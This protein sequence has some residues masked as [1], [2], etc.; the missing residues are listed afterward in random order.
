MRGLVSIPGWSTIM[1]CLLW[2]RHDN[3]TVFLHFIIQNL[4]VYR[5]V[6][7]R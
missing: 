3:V 7:N 4:V 1:Y 6:A 2:A 5:V